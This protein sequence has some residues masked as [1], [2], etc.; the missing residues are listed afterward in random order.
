MSDLE[1][2]KQ[3]LLLDLYNSLKQIESQ[4]DAIPSQFK[5]LVEALA[6][7][8]EDSDTYLRQTQPLVNSLSYLRILMMNARDSLQQY[9]RVCSVGPNSFDSNLDR[10]SPTKITTKTV[11]YVIVIKPSGDSYCGYCIDLPECRA[12]GKTLEQ[13]RQQLTQA[14]TL[15]LNRMV[16]DGK[17]IPQS[18][19]IVDY[20]EMKMPES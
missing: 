4:L 14:L 16:N 3:K 8:L 9:C 17:S 15:R 6:Q 13:V 11:R 20:I 12:K 10:D 19:T 5:P 7:S 1:L 18:K 2:K